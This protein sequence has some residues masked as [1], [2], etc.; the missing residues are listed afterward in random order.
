MKIAKWFL[1]KIFL[2][3]IL[4]VLLHRST[5]FCNT[6]RS[7]VTQD[8][9][10]SKTPTSQELWACLLRAVCP[11][12][13]LIL[14]FSLTG[15]G[16][17]CATTCQGH[18]WPFL[19]ILRSVCDIEAAAAVQE[20]PDVWW[21]RSCMRAVITVHTGKGSYSSSSIFGFDGQNISFI[22][23]FIWL[24]LFTSP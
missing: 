13:L 20:F 5:V 19:S 17:K 23:I 11:C 7:A 24:D 3:V 15:K 6:V 2:C 14:C 4:C 12:S 10:F 1:F 21:Q 18:L 8:P 22:C 16:S 9:T